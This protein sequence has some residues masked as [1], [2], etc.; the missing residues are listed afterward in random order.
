FARRCLLH[1]SDLRQIFF[2]RSGGGLT[3]QLIELLA[4]IGHLTAQIVESF[5]ELLH[6]L[7]NRLG[8]QRNGNN[9]DDQ[10]RYELTTSGHGFPPVLCWLKRKP[11]TKRE[12][13]GRE[14]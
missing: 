1:A 9:Q 10:Q 13:L 6:A 14:R 12:A 2:W 7:F 5:F 8:R 4:D 3:L 11:A